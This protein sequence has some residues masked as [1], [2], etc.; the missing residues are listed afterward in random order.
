MLGST[1]TYGNI[2]NLIP[3]WDGQA[4][5]VIPNYRLNA[6]GYVALRELSETDPRGTSGNYGIT[7]CIAALRW[8]QENIAVF[9]GDAARVTVFGQSSG[10]TNILTLFAAPS[11]RGLFHRAISLSGSPNITMDLATVEHQ[12]LG[13]VEGTTCTSLQGNPLLDC[14]YN[15]SMHDVL[16]AVPANWSFEFAFPTSPQ[17]TIYPGLTIVD[18]V[19]VTMPLLDALRTGLVDVPIILQSMECEA[20]L[21]PTWARA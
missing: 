21:F 2:Q 3:L 5:I 6:F 12:G 11:A 17:G 16:H 10:G 14:L 9:G 7:D 18:G 19:T 20:D 15:L 4:V 1:T 8:V 13:L